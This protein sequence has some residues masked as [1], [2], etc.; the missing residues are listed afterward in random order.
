L[1][2]DDKEAG[3]FSSQFVVEASIMHNIEEKGLRLVM[4]ET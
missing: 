3:F 1:A 2:L 4:S